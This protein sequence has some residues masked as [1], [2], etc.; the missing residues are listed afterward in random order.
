MPAKPKKEFALRLLPLT[1][2]LPVFLSLLTLSQPL[3]GQ[4]FAGPYLAA[5]QADFDRD[6]AVAVEYGIRAIARDPQNSALMEG[7]LV[8]QV[9]LGQIDRATPIATRLLALEPDNQIAG[10]VMLAS[11]IRNGHWD[12]ILDLLGQGISIGVAIDE[13]IRAWA[14][15]GKGDIQTALA[16]LSQVE[17]GEDPGQFLI[18]HRALLLAL[19]G[20]YAAAAQLLSGRESEGV[21]LNRQGIIVYAQILS[22]L[23]RNP[24]AVEL[25]DKAFPQGGDASVRTMRSELAAGKPLTFDAVTSPSQALS[26]VFASVA[27]ALAREMQPEVVLLYSRIAEYLDPQNYEATLLSAA[28]LELLELYDL[29]VETYARVPEGDRLYRPAS[30]ARAEALRRAGKP[31][32]AI[33]VLQGLAE[34]YPNNPRIW[35]TLGDTYRVTKRCDQALAPYDRALS[36]YEKPGNAQWSLFFARGICREQQDMWDDAEADFLKALELNPNQPS[37]LNYL[38]YSW[39][40]QR[41]NLDQALDM[42]RRAVAARPEDGYITDS[43]GWVNYRLG[44]YQEAVRDMERA[45]ELIPVD[46]VLNDHLGDVYWAVGRRLEAQF[47]W[48]RALSFITDDTDLDEIDPDRI[49]RK[50]EVGLDKVLQEEGAPPLKR[51][52]EG[53]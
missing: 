52:D 2:L 46:P 32:Q 51:S 11:G 43:L 41:R 42:I 9:G 28:L 17:E 49:R 7:L 14:H 25:I 15:F 23:E 19:S 24:A 5:R 20:D 21:R 4:G 36:L 1:R 29:A 50:L 26:D 53:G 40:E 16:N 8:A 13:L 6:F 37:V 22:Q 34:A 18:Y 31:D 48:R 38:G 35:K 47:Q 39:V 27:Q 30:L 10:L 12:D 45:V 33:E 44:N 3:H